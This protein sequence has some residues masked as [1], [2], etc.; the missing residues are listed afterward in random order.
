MIDNDVKSYIL[1]RTFINE[2]N[3]RW[4][5]LGGN[6]DA[7]LKQLENSTPEDVAKHRANRRIFFFDF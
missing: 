7:E 3:I 5:V 2:N 4:I 1:V 6:L